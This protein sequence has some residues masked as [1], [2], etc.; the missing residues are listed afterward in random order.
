MPPQDWLPAGGWD[1]IDR[2]PDKGIN[3]FMELSSPQPMAIKLR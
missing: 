3:S 1:V 2:C